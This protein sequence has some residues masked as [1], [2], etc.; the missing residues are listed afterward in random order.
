MTDLA[1]NLSKSTIAPLSL[2][3]ERIHSTFELLNLATNLLINE[4]TYIPFPKRTSSKKESPV[5]IK[6]HPYIHIRPSR[7]DQPAPRLT[8]MYTSTNLARWARLYISMHHTRYSHPAIEIT[9]EQK[10]SGAC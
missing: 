2:D 9:G 10:T 3:L 4:H 6:G 8:K 1:Q 5:Y 7:F